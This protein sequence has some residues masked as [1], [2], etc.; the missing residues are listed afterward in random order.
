M[1]IESLHVSDSVLSPFQLL[2]H[3]IL[4]TRKHYYYPHLT[5][6]EMETGSVQQLAGGHTAPQQRG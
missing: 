3:L 6:G 2:S 5:E 1:L 4:T